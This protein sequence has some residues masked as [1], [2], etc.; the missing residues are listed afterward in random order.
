MITCSFVSLLAW[1]EKEGEPGTTNYAR[2][3][4][5]NVL[6]CQP[7]REP[8]YGDL[9]SGRGRISVRLQHDRYVRHGKLSRQMQD[10]SHDIENA[11]HLH[12]GE[13]IVREMDCVALILIVL[14]NEVGREVAPDA[15]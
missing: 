3:F 7:S 15:S 12:V 13:H 6:T 8:T 2:T 5:F 10:R 9:G 1:H 4:Q 14:D 11:T